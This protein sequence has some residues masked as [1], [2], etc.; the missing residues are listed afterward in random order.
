VPKETH[1]FISERNYSLPYTG[2]EEAI[3]QRIDSDKPAAWP[4]FIKALFHTKKLALPSK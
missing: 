1:R 3:E 2:L 4:A